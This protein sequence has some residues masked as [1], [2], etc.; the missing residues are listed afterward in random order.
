VSE[1][2][3]IWSTDA[4]EAIASY[5]KLDADAVDHAIA[6][7][8]EL[9]RD[10]KQT[11][12]SL[13]DGELAP[14]ANQSTRVCLERWLRGFEETITLLAR[15]SDAQ[16]LANASDL[17]VA[18]APTNMDYCVATPADPG[19]WQMTVHAGALATNGN[20]AAAVEIADAAISRADALE[21]PASGSERA[22][23]H[24]ARAEVAMRS[25]DDERATLEFDLALRHAYASN[26][27]Q[28]LLEIFTLKAR[29]LAIDE[30]RGNAD[31]AFIHIEQAELI[32]DSLP[33]GP[34]DVLRAQL[35]DTRGLAERARA[36]AALSPDEARQQ[37]HEAIAHH[38]E[39]Q[40][41]FRAA[42]RPTLAAKALL[43]V[44]LN[45][46]NLGDPEQ[47]R[48]SYAE[49]STLLD[50]ARV[51]PS[52]R[53]RVGIERNLGLLAS[54]TGDTTALRHF[55][56]VLEHGNEAER[57]EMHEQ[58]LLLTLQFGDEELTQVWIERAA[59]ALSARPDA[60]ID[61]IFRIQRAVGFGLALYGDPRG[62]LLLAA[63]ERSSE[64]LPLASQ[65]NLQ[66]GWIE[67]LELMERC[68]EASERRE[69]LAVRLAQ[70]EPKLAH[71]Y[72]RW[73]AAGP[74]STCAKDSANDP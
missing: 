51:P 33:G 55:E 58:I 25:G 45:Y 28:V 57:F 9:A 8:D 50:D 7:L 19:I 29:L 69:Q 68:D 63:A 24:M 36:L 64:A 17:L 32:F 35:L 56:F 30:T 14:A 23:A 70:A 71:A 67:W 73:R 49:A 59:A 27:E 60:S 20:I 1:I 48:R 37:H 54:E 61:D 31:R 46:Q 66:K 11:A 4:H 72:A 3:E 74:P 18:L 65:F 53:S 34:H 5:H 62:E 21:A 38:N 52:Y 47:A 26:D 10:W 16:I 15:R 12:T 39:A 6:K 22:L 13:C 41:L 40:L 43:H 2:D 42:G 44:G